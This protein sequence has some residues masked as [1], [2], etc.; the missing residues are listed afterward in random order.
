MKIA[1]FVV[2]I[3]YYYMEVGTTSEGRFTLWPKVE[4]LS[5]PANQFARN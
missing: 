1:K 3:G 4:R 2:A 5:I